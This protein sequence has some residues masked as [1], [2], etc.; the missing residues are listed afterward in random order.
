[1]HIMCALLVDL[2]FQEAWQRTETFSLSEAYYV[3]QVQ[4][5]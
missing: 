1:M 5:E 4:D 3:T 2:H